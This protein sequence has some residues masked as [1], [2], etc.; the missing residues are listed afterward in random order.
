MTTEMFID[1]TPFDGKTT[2]RINSGR[3]TEPTPK[4]NA[5]KTGIA[6]LKAERKQATWLFRQAWLEAQ[7][8]HDTHA[9]IIFAQAWRRSLNYKTNKRNWY[10]CTPADWNLAID[11]LFGDECIRAIDPLFTPAGELT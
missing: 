5:P 7:A 11:Y 10:N 1:K 3:Y 9:S 2:L 6:L 4:I 8:S